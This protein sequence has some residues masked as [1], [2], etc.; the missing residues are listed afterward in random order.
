ME[1]FMDKTKI[2]M[3][4]YGGTKKARKIFIAMSKI[5]MMIEVALYD[6]IKLL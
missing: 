4:I 5:I 3:V 1:I 2:F 6:K